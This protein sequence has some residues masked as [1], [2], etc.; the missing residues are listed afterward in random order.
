MKGLMPLWR[1]ACL[2]YFRR[3]L[4]EINPMHDDVPFLVR[5]INDLSSRSN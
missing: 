1:L 4:R 2:A 5:R 3:A